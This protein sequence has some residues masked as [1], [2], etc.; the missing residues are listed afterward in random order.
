[1]TYEYR[2]IYC[3]LD[4]LFVRLKSQRIYIKMTILN[5][6]IQENSSV[7]YDEISSFAG[8]VVLVFYGLIFIFGLLGI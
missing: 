2:F 1:M 4:E 3:Y 6:T 7:D 8:R 5:T